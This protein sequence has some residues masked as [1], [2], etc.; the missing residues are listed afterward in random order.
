MGGGENYVI[1]QT[2][3]T[4]PLRLIHH[5]KFGE[6]GIATP[7][8][9]TDENKWADVE[10]FGLSCDVVFPPFRPEGNGLFLFKRLFVSMSVENNANI[11]VH[12][13]CYL[14][15]N[16]PRYNTSREQDNPDYKTSFVAKN[17]KITIYL[18]DLIS[19]EITLRFEWLP[20]IQK[21]GQRR[22][23]NKLSIKGVQ[24]EAEKY[25]GDVYE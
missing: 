13:S 24:I 20:S 10:E 8:Y 21:Y 22:V 5:Q 15:G 25:A 6:W 17:G 18:P 19:E 23:I 9:Y 3:G 16:T 2:D 1:P 11:T 7:S 14:K 12:L 4:L